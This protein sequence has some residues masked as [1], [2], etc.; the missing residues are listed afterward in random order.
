[1]ELEEMQLVWS[2]MNQQL[3]Q[4]KKLTDK[5]IIDMTQ[6]KYD[7]KLK[8]ISTFETIGA[9]VCFCFFILVLINFG[10]L[11]TWY[12]MLCGLFCLAFY[13]FFPIAILRSIRQLRQLNLSENNYK[14]TL[15]K[16]AKRKKQFLLLQKAGII[17]SFLLLIA[18][19]P[20]VVKIFDEKDIFLSGDVWIWY[21]PIGMTF[22]F[23]LSRWGYNAYDRITDSAENLIKELEH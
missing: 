8:T 3:A 19:L 20:V 18:C 10:K 9:I 17:C 1:M 11:D 16:Y 14:T 2:E 5:I 21:L 13:L 6:Q 22:L 7:Q 4:Q 23:L 15:L 12:L